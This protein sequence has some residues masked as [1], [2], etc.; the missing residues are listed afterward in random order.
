MIMR[1]A[2]GL[3][4]A[5]ATGGLAACTSPPPP[6][7]PAPV[8]VPGRPGEPASTIP[9]GQATPAPVTPPNANDIEYMRRMIEHHQQAIEMSVLA[10]DRAAAENVKLVADRI[11]DAQGPEIEAMNGWLRSHGQPTVEPGA[12]PGHAGH[13]AATMPGMATPAQLDALRAA[14]GADFDKLYLQLMI[15]HHQGALTM[16]REVQTRGIDERVQLIADEVIA[17]QS[18][19]ITR[20]QA[21]TGQ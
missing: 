15:T 13:D 20:L 21:L 3:S 11:A 17:T 9:P 2:C 19:E 8:L 1:L 14:K 6:E 10:P 7:D 5:L 4:V 16:A 12:H 18:A